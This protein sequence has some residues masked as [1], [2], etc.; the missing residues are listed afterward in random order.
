MTGRTMAFQHSD[1]RRRGTDNVG[2]H[3]TEL[4]D[5]RQRVKPSLPSRNWRWGLTLSRS[6]AVCRARPGTPTS[7]Q[8][9]IAAPSGEPALPAAVVQQH[10]SPII[11]IA[12]VGDD[13][14]SRDG[15]GTCPYALLGPTAE[16]E[17][18]PATPCRLVKTLS[19]GS[20]SP[21][22]TVSVTASTSFDHLMTHSN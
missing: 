5:D 19:I 11:K 6:T 21:T 7:G 13:A 20:P 1:A 18:K 8:A 10:N 22:L 14:E 4:L 2:A 9:V 15:I 17:T 3:R 12:L 16:H